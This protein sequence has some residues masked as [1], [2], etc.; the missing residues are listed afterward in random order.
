MAHTKRQS[1]ILSTKIQ[2]SINSIYFPASS[3][4]L[5]ENPSKKFTNIV[6]SNGKK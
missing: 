2:I 1:Y 3:S 4:S 5:S 6:N